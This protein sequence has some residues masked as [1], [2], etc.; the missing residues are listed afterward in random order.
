MGWLCRCPGIVWEPIRKQAHAQLVRKRSTTVVSA[1]WA[2]VDWPWHKEWNKCGRANV[3]FKKT[4]NKQTNKKSAGGE[5]MVQHSPTILASEEK[6]S[7]HHLLITSASSS[8]HYSCIGSIECS[9]IPF[10][11]L[12]FLVH[13][14]LLP[15]NPF[16]GVT[17][18]PPSAFPLDCIIVP[19]LFRYV[20]AALCIGVKILC[21]I[22]TPSVFSSFRVHLH[23]N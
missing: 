23:I 8:L 9:P 19:R 5:W 4:T 12:C 2:T 20:S 3:H 15:L 7:S 22:F 1:R 18:L 13:H 14:I 10:L 21:S 6:A 16:V 17:N 11:F